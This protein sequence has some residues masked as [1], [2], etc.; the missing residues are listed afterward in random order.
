MFAYWCL[1]DLLDAFITK[2]GVES[3]NGS[4][5]VDGRVIGI[6]GTVLIYV[7]VSTRVVK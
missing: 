3:V 6:S 5:S 1:N 4:V 7:A 2:E